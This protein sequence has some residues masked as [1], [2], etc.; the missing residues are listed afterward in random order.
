M[1]N[2]SMPKPGNDVL[3]YNCVRFIQREML[4]SETVLKSMHKI[5]SR[6]ATD[7]AFGIRREV[8]G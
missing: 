5:E 4:G 8:T 7:I 3:Y 1:L 6:M 2:M